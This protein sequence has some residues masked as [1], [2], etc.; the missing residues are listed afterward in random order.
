M[1]GPS[2]INNFNLVDIFVPEKSFFWDRSPCLRDQSRW[3][4]TGPLELDSIGSIVNWIRK[5]LI[6][7][8]ILHQ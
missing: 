6:V 5:E 8:V 7:E 4:W 1:T 3:C 2:K